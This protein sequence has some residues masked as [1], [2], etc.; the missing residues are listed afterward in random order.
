MRQ[1][2]AKRAME[3]RRGSLRNLAKLLAP[4]RALTPLSP[5]L[6]VRCSIQQALLSSVRCSTTFPQTAKPGPSRI[7]ICSGRT[8]SSHPFYLRGNAPVMSVCPLGPGGSATGVE[9]P[10]MAAKSSMNPPR[11]NICRSFSARKDLSG[12]DLRRS[13]FQTLIS[14]R[15]PW[16]M[17]N[18]RPDLPC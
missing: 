6:D 4:P 13:T 5:W 3:L 15:P 9:K 10:L 14:H 16:R 2:R 7:P 1:R 17:V 11:S 12:S 8:C 18:P